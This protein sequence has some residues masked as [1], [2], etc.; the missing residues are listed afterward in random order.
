MVI[1]KRLASASHR[2]AVKCRWGVT[3]VE[4]I[5]V[6][7][8]VGLLAAIILPAVQAARGASQRMQC[9]NNQR[10]LLLAI[11]SYHDTYRAFPPCWGWPGAGGCSR[12]T[13]M[14]RLF[15]FLGLPS[16]CDVLSS[17]VRRL[18]I[19]ECPSDPEIALVQTP[20][21]YI[22]NGSPGQSSG[23]PYHGPFEDVPN[24]VVCSA[25]ITDGLSNTAAMS[26]NIT[27]R[28]GGSS[29]DATREPRRYAWNV[30]V[31]ILSP[32]CLY[33]SGTPPC[34]AERTQQTDDSIVDCLNGPR[35]FIP[36]P[37][38]KGGQWGMGDF[39]G[40]AT[41]T[42]SHWYPPNSPWCFGGS[43]TDLTFITNNQRAASAHS[44]GVNVG[45][46]DCHVRFVGDQ[47]D[48]AIW[49]AIGT[50]DGG[51]TNGELP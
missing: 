2:C 15:P 42:Y 43:L 8:I 49:R 1:A 48:Q 25:D 6:I 39:G 14:T 27:M 33:N 21:S 34:L 37:F 50:R 19:L 17:D 9:A 30:F 44:G 40:V 3:L 13:A 31:P 51:E 4:I 35:D 5:V 7:S 45:F 22:L 46:L 18:P 41:W 32:P 36:S 23:V 20:L 26:E 28:A 29:T 11:A 12:E 24:R 16:I 38:V 47:V 10:Q